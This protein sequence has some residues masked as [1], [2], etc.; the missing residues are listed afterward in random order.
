MN[1]T[2][3]SRILH[4][5]NGLDEI[6]AKYGNPDTNSD[7]ILDPE[8]YAENTN[9]YKL[10]QPLRLSWNPNS[11]V[12]HIRAHRS[13]GFA[14]VQAIDDMVNYKGIEWLRERNYDHYGGCFEF[15]KMRNYPGLST[16]SWGIAIDLVPQLG[17]MGDNPDRYPEFIVDIFKSYGF[18]WGGDWQYPDAM[19]FQMCTGY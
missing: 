18:A 7:Y 8:W 1:D 13:V 3:E 19:H 11:T 12:R 16:H 6:I 15:R 10:T 4:L 9:A 14:F 2:T 5:P 17:G